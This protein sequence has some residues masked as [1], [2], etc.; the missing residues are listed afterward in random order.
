M[1]LCAC[2]SLFVAFTAAVLL[3]IRTPMLPPDVNVCI[4]RSKLAPVLFCCVLVFLIRSGRRMVAARSR[5]YFSFYNLTFHTGACMHPS[6]IS[7]QPGFGTA[8]DL[9]HQHQHERENRVCVPGGHTP[10]TSVYVHA[11]L[12]LSCPCPSSTQQLSFFNF[13]FSISIF[14]FTLPFAAVASRL[15]FRWDTSW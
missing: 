12:R 10:A 15:K 7:T 9:T 6:R 11:P 14:N 4:N 5:L 1:C 8:D 2:C 13:Q 3:L